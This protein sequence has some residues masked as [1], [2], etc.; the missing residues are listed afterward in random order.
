MMRRTAFLTLLLLLAVAA[1]AAER[2]RLIVVISID[3]F[4]YEYLERFAPWFG[5][6]GFKRFLDSGADFTN[7]NYLHA[8]TFTGPGHASIGTGRTPSESGIVANTWF[9]RDAP[10]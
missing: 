1:R 7:C 9:E 6:R 2:P 8:T 4:R 5:E 10:Y 3:Q